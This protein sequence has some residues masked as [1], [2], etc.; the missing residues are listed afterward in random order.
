MFHKVL[1]ANRGEIA[2][3]IA[4]TCREL[5]VTSIAVYSDADR[6]ARHVATCD[7]AW[8]IGPPSPS[9]SYLNSRRILDVARQSG[10][11]AIHP[12]YG[13]L[14]ENT[15]FAMACRQQNIRFIGPPAH[16]ITCMGLK[17]MAK[18]TMTKIGIPLIPGYHDD[19][20]DD[21]RLFKEA[22]QIGFPLLIKASA[23]GGGKGMRIVNDH[24]EFFGALEAARREAKNAFGNS[25]VILEKYIRSPRH[26][27][28]QV[29][30][31]QHGNGIH[32]FERDCS[33]Q[34]RYQKIIELA[35]APGIDTDTRNAMGNT[36]IQAA[37]AIDYEGAGTVEFIVDSE[38]KFYFMEMNTRLQ[39]EHPVTEM[40]TGIDLVAWQLRIAAGETL[41]LTQQQLG[42]PRGHAIEA[43][44]YAEDPDNGFLPA[45]GTVQ[46][47]HTPVTSRHLRIDSGIREGDSIGIHYD[48]MIAKLIVWD[49][50]RQGAI[51]RLQRALNDYR[52]AGLANNLDFLSRIAHSPAF[53]EGTITTNFLDD[54]SPTTDE[55]PLSDDLYALATL[56]LLQLESLPGH[57]TSDPYSPWRNHDAWRNHGNGRTQRHLLH[58][59]HAVTVD[60]CF[61]ASGYRL[62][63]QGRQWTGQ[64]KSLDNHGAMEVTLNGHSRKIHGFLNNPCLS[65]FT[66]QQRYTLMI[67]DGSMTT[68]SSTSIHGALCAPMPGI[69]LKVFGK[70]GTLVSA[71]TPLMILEAMKMEHTIS[72]PKS[73]IIERLFY[74]PGDA[75]SE[76]AELLTISPSKPADQ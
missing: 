70:Q 19:D 66:S 41:P 33:L 49:Q 50:Q 26:I 75:V 28:I 56:A 31:D 27:E 15:E 18:Q 42:N 23:G 13:F 61:T 69:I 21:D 62:S 5:G 68:E 55:K 51:R 43:R 10:A 12:G 39:V 46:F 63:I 25:A 72:A 57:P 16:A 37:L 64:I 9:K 29:F 74:Q 4:R 40:I 52:L 54:Q 45:T 34:R 71:G 17:G 22:K 6:N 1:I 14:S 58:H 35:P 7:E 65:V 24:R 73:G 76:G 60:I 47:L 32:L 11:D 59:D 44:I 36:A 2:C 20:Q 30:T 38:N 48:P 67:D 8:H 3:R 53:I